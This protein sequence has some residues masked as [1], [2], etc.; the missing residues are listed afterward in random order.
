MATVFVKINRDPCVMI[1][2]FSYSTV[3]DF[4]AIIKKISLIF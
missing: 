1:F 3:Y 4:I 2:Y